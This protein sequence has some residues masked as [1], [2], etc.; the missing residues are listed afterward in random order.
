LPIYSVPRPSTTPQ[1]RRVGR[2]TV[3]R[4]GGESRSARQ[5]CGRSRRRHRGRRRRAPAA[6]PLEPRASFV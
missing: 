5:H 4:H 1:H 6:V 3:L 2:A